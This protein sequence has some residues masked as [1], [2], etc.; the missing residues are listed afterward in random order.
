VLAT[1][2]GVAH[3]FR[4]SFQVI[5]LGANLLAHLCENWGRALQWNAELAKEW[6]AEIN[7]LK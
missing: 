1:K 5:G 4:I 3:P 6:I 2:P 7:D